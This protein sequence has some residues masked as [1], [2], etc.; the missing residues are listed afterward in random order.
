[1]PTPPACRVYVPA[2][3]YPS[4]PPGTFCWFKANEI[5]LKGVTCDNGKAGC[6][7][8]VVAPTS[9]TLDTT[10][11]PTYA[12][13]GGAQP[14]GIASCAVGLH[15]EVF[16]GQRGAGINPILTLTPN[17]TSTG[18]FGEGMIKTMHGM[19][20]QLHATVTSGGQPPLWTTDAGNATVSKWDPTNGARLATV[21][22][23]KGT[24]THPLQ[25]GSVADVAFDDSGAV[26]ISDGDGGVNARVLKLDAS[27]ELV[28]ANGNNGTLATNVAWASPHSLA[29]DASADR[30]IVADRNNNRLRFLNA[31]S[32][33]LLGEWS[34]STFAVGNCDLPAVWAVRIDNASGLVL[35]GTSN[36]GAGAGCPPPADADK[37]GVIVVLNLPPPGASIAAPNVVTKIPMAHGFPHE[38]CVDASTGAVYAAAVDTSDLPPNVGL[39]AITKYVPQRGAH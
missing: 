29:Y 36:F 38:I 13:K 10:W 34:P 25:F 11:K 26:Y 9:Y 18:G 6:V 3:L 2:G 39:G 28:W 15:G 35:V 5:S 23:G 22:A 1:M 19:K 24:A 31:A 12:S 20:S 37:Q 16:V 32:G 30:V 17:G 4:R 8:G 33:A 7:S 27:L 21:G 14:S